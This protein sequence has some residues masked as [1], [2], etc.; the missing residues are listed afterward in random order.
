ML[1]S[2]ESSGAAGQPG[3]DVTAEVAARLE[4]EVAALLGAAQTVLAGEVNLPGGLWI[5]T[6]RAVA[7]EPGEPV[8]PVQA[9]L[10]GFGRTDDRRGAGAA[11]RAAWTCDDS[12]E[13]AR[14]LAGLLATPLVEPEM[15]VRQG[16]FLVSRLLPWARS[17][18]L[19]DAAQRTTTSLAPTERGAI[20]NLRLTEK[21]V[22]PPEPNEVQVRIEAA[23]LNFRDVLN[24]L[25]LYP[26]DPGPIGGDLG[27]VGHR[28]GCRGHRIR[29]RPAGLRLHA[30]RLRQPAQRAGP[31]AGPD[32]GRDQ[33]GG[34]G[35]HSRRGADGPAGV[36]L[37][38]AQA[39]RQGAHPRRQRW[40]RAWPRSRW[41]SSTARPSSPPRAS[42]SAPRCARWAWSTSTTRGQRIS[43][44]RFSRTPTARAWTWCSTA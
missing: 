33:R 24:V 43:R 35:D 17:G 37:G 42:T 26:G 18:Q 25:G 34:R 40:R 30:G 11:V 10:W 36:R 28:I 21:E 39:R 29:G 13:A 22:T 4:S 14:W 23:G 31:A 9:A 8:D 7:T 19:T 6:E 16:K 15:A 2:P 5:V 20:D 44:T 41:P 38:A 3:T 1:P 27:G 12:P 32:A